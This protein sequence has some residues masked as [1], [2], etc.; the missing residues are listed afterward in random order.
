M[1]IE[2]S[3][4]AN[5]QARELE[6]L[7]NQYKIKAYKIAA[8]IRRGWDRQEVRELF[9]ECS[10]APHKA[11]CTTSVGRDE[12]DE[13]ETDWRERYESTREAPYGCLTEDDMKRA[14]RD[15]DLDT[16]EDNPILANIALGNML[17]ENPEFE[18]ELDSFIRNHKGEDTIS[19]D[20]LQEQEYIAANEYEEFSEDEQDDAQCVVDYWSDLP[21]TELSLE[22]LAMIEEQ[23]SLSPKRETWQDQRK[24]SKA[25]LSIF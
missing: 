14:I 21:D 22:A 4:A 10:T 23:R 24:L 13:Q 15:G 1:G 18:E 5:Y 7:F 11:K 12:D 8:K 20:E 3:L 16:I 25:L 19:L 2:L 6:A 9:D 17:R